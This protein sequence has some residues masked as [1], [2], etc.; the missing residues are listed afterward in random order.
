MFRIYLKYNWDSDEGKVSL[1]WLSS[2]ILMVDS[3]IDT[4]RSCSMSVFTQMAHVTC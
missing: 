3:E 4:Y 1:K 2:S